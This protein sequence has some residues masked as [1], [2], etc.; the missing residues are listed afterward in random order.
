MI[1][2]ELTQDKFFLL[3][4][5]IVTSMSTTER[6]RWSRLTAICFIFALCSIFGCNE[7][8]LCRT[9]K[10]DFPYKRKSI[11]TMT[12]EAHY[13]CFI[14]RHNIINCRSV[15]LSMERFSWYG[16]QGSETVLLCVH[17]PG[18]ALL[19]VDTSFICWC[20]SSSMC[21]YSLK[22]FFLGEIFCAS[23]MSLTVSYSAQ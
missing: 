18:L 5:F 23:F 9:A 10:N 12:I 3:L 17:F 7:N 2:M 4:K 8:Q 22:A 11:N 21:L 14:C 19:V 6:G 16:Y 20:Y 13:S 1:K 15:C